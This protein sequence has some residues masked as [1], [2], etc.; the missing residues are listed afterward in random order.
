MNNGV[1]LGPRARDHDPTAPNGESAA[2]DRLYTVEQAAE[3]LN[4]NERFV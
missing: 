3:R 1:T 2:F 4:T